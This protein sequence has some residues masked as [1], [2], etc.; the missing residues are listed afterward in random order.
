PEE[1]W[2]VSMNRDED[3][4]VNDPQ[5]LAE[6]TEV[7]AAC[8]L[9]LKIRMPVVVDELDD[10][11]ARAYGALP[12]R[13]YLIGQGGHIAFQ[14]APGPWGFDPAALEAAIEAEVG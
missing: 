11:I 2:V 14:G 8:A 4:V 3:I 13:L 1:G 10:N 9:R 7:A 5:T 6:R 12:D